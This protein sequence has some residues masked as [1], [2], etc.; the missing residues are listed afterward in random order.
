[1]KEY[2]TEAIVLGARPIREHDRMVDLYTKSLGKVSVKVHGGRKIL[3]KLSP[4]LDVL[5]LVKARLIQKKQFT[6][7]DVITEDRFSLIRENSKR[8]SLGLNLLFLLKSVLPDHSPDLAFWHHLSRALKKGSINGEFFLKLLGYDPFLADCEVCREKDIRFF[9][10]KN[11][12][13]FCLRCGLKFKEKE[14][15][16]LP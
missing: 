1:M 15:I 10:L 2:F 14:V 9:N 13:F 12:S 16:F 7:A 6:L 8:F 5:N 3:S 4:H 11:Q